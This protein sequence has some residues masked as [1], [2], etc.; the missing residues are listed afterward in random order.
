MTALENVPETK[1]FTA[2]LSDSIADNLQ[3]QKIELVKLGGK[4]VP[5]SLK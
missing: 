4:R 1:E 5:V 3:T 2:I